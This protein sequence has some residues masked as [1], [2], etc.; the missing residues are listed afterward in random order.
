MKITKKN[1]LLPISIVATALVTSGIAYAVTS[2]NFSN[3]AALW[4]KTNCTSALS[5]SKATATNEQK[6][7]ICY[8]YNK[9]NEQDT[10]ILN[11]QQNITSLQ[12]KAKSLWVYD[13]NGVKL[14]ISLTKSSQNNIF[15]QIYN[16]DMQKIVDINVS[17]NTSGAIGKLIDVFYSGPNCTGQAYMQ[18][19]TGLHYYYLHDELLKDV[20][21]NYYSVASNNIVSVQKAS[22]MHP[23]S[24]EYCQSD[25]SIVPAIELSGITNS[26]PNIVSLPLSYQFQ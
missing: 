24:V 9:N 15:E 5:T 2:L 14:G 19:Q 21:S 10:S 18:T 13:S 12:T 4:A 16:T 26:L 23:G 25:N 8:N 22:Y 6:S 17:E 11:Q 7:I 3:Q 1:L 20:F